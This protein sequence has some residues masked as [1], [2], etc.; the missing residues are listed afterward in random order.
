MYG[1]DYK[2][3]RFSR[4]TQ[5]NRENVHG[6]KPAWIYQP[7]R[8]LQP[9]ES[10][11][12]VVN[13]IMYVTEPLS[14]VTALDA[15]LGTKIWSW[16]AHLPDKIYHHW[17]APL[18]SRSGCSRRYRLRGNARRASCRARRDD[19]RAEMERSRGRQRSRLRDDRRAARARRESDRRNLRRRR[20][21][22]RFRR[23]LRREDRQ[24]ALAHLDH[25]GARR[26]G[27][28]N[29]GKRH[30]RHR[31]RRHLG[32]RL[33]RPGAESAVLDDGKSCTR[34]QRCEPRGRQPLYQLRAGHG[35]RHR[36]NKVVFPVHAP[37]HARL[38]RHS[39]SRVIRRDS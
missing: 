25:S 3:Q 5:I 12:V 2:S 7:S 35:S 19:R 33:V 8:P 28:G 32:H 6:L 14:T 24:A 39:G 4:L 15:R 20:R 34:L 1:G 23:R 17:R 10:S 26:A 22:S 11:A 31:R 18:E 30:V 21:D 27:F 13:G 38:G 36:K 29:V 16:S 37:R 9:I